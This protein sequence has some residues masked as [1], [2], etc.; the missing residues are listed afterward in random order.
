MSGPTLAELSEKVALVSDTY[1]QNCDIARDDDWYA[2]KLSEEVGELVAEHLR[3]SGRGRR[4]G[5][6]PEQI[7]EALGDEAADVLA[8]TLLYAR[9]NGIDLVAALER[10]WFKYLKAAPGAEAK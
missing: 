2:L 9:H 5:M 1:A 4:A 6:S 8:M 7:A 10:K 3:G